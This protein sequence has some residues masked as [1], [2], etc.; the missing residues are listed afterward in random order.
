M[1]DGLLVLAS[2]SPRRAELLRLAG[3][4]F[5]V[6]PADLDETPRARRTTGGV[7]PPPGRGQGRGGGCR[8]AGAVVLGADTTVVVD[9][10]MLGKP[11]DDAEAC[12]HAERLQGR[13]HDVL[14]G[15]AWPARPDATAPC[16][17]TRVWFAPMSAGEI[18]GYVASGEPMR[19][20]RRL[21]ASR[22]WRRGM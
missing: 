8:S 15:V 16:A 10:A 6:A 13:A 18:A 17:S 5:T 2:A 4:A 1:L 19:Q 12:G 7:R 14:T 11:A 22:G 9:G 3:F 20:G 21:R